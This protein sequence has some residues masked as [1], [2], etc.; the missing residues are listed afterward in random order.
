M[1]D[2]NLRPERVIS[3]HPEPLYVTT[4]HPLPFTIRGVD[5][6]RQPGKSVVFQRPGEVDNSALQT[7]LNVR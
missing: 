6:G 2:G 3:S 7:N 5:I 4:K 1:H